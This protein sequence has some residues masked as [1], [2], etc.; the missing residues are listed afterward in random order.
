M[1]DFTSCRRGRME[2]NF[3][4][5]PGSQMS[6]HKIV[7][8]FTLIGVLSESKVFIHNFSPTSCST[9]TESLHYPAYFRSAY[10]TVVVKQYGCCLFPYST[11]TYHFLNIC[12]WEKKILLLPLILY[13]PPSV[14]YVLKLNFDF[15]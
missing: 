13:T 2:F 8:I 3:I 6:Q 12:F 15:L 9:A 7:F 11:C 14:I 10:I 1:K 4:S 5:K